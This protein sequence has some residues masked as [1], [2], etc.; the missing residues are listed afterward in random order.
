MSKKN[1]FKRS[2][3]YECTMT[4]ENFTTGK[5]AKHPGELLSIKAYYEMHPEEDDRPAPIKQIIAQRDAENAAMKELQNKDK[6][7][8]T[9]ANSSNEK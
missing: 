6:A 4:G 3:R 7:E 5:E 1:K 2:Y 8:A 9:P